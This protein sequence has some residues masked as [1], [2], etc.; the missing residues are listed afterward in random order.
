MVRRSLSRLLAAGSRHRLATISRLVQAWPTIGA[1]RHQT[2]W[3]CAAIFLAGHLLFLVG[4]TAPGE[5]YF[6]EIY[7]VGAARQ[8]LAHGPPQNPEHPPLVKELIAASI[9]AW[10]D[11]ALGWRYMSA[12]FGAAALAGI[13]AWAFLLFD[14]RPAALWTT[15][16]TFANQMLYVQSRLAMLDVFMVAFMI[17]AMVPFTASWRSRRVRSCFAASGAC[18]GLSVASKWVGL[19]PWL[20]V[21]A[22]VIAVK[23]LQNWKVRFEE[24]TATDWYR[25]DLWQEMRPLD[26]IASLVLLPAALYCLTFVPAFGWDLGDLIHRQGEMWRGLAS[27]T[28]AHPYSSDWSGWPIAMRPIWYLFEP[29]PGTPEL[30]QAVVFLGNPVILWSGVAAIATCLYGWLSTARRDAFIVSINWL[31]LYGT[32]ALVPKKTSFFYYYFPA[33]M[34]LSL[35]LAYAFYTT[36]LGKWPWLRHA[37]LGLSLGIFLYFLPVTSAAITVTLSGYSDRI[38]FDSWR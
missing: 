36:P 15:A 28:A 24:A 4:L 35:A 14:S 5:P 17:W 30:T 19:I 29:V 13:Y 34:V 21:V 2:L 32:W 7:Y 16:L 37:F 10:G 33:G 20:T 6:D 38:W 27:V 11:N 9:A 1:V 23:I 26:W 22:T 18:L 31:A 25:P 12:L 8:L 3:I